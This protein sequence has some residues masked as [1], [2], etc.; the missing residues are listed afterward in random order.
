MG[1]LACG[2]WR[3]AADAWY[4][5]DRSAL[6]ALSERQ[7]QMA[8]LHVSL[9]AELAVGQMTMPGAMEMTLIGRCYERLGAHAVNLARR[10][11][12]LAGSTSR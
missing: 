7:E 9:A 2:M 3:Q 5:R 4:D 10:L 1:D 8:E 12:Y 11:T 6:P